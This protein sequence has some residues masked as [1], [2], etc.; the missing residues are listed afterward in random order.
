MEEDGEDFLFPPEE[1]FDIENMG[2]EP[3]NRDIQS[4]CGPPSPDVIEIEPSPPNGG[5][6]ISH[7]PKPAPF[8][9]P[10]ASSS[11]SSSSST[12]PMQ[13][14]SARQ[15]SSDTSDNAVEFQGPY[16][17]TQ[18]MMK[19]FTQVVPPRNSL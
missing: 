8:K 3:K 11:S 19:I 12:T 17:H 18:E 4:D 10:F 1:L 9:P 15:P 7:Q 14:A 5:T 16:S 13:P 6:Q 2:G